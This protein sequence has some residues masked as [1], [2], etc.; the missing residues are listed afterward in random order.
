[1]DITDVSRREFIGGLA[2]L[3]VAGGMRADERSAATTSVSQST[4]EMPYRSLGKTG[5]K[6]SCIGLGGFHLGQ[7]HLQEADAIQLFHAAVDRGINFS[8][9]SW[10]YNQN[11]LRQH[12]FST[13]RHSIRNGWDTAPAPQISPNGIEPLVPRK[14]GAR[15]IASFH[16][17]AP[18]ESRIRVAAFRPAKPG[19][20]PRALEKI[21]S[22]LFHKEGLIGREDNRVITVVRIVAYAAAFE[23][24]VIRR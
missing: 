23:I 2:M 17:T 19:A 8:D 9:N 1:M 24:A 18:T 13:Q 20:V 12:S 14:F 3:T 15:V 7:P 5:E 10:D 4:Q 22:R 11:R 6:V 21:D 16:S